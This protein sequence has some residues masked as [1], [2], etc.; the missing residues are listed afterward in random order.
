[1]IDNPFDILGLEP[2]YY[3]E[4]ELKKAYMEALQKNPPEK[5]PQG[6]KRIRK[7]YEDIKKSMS[8]YGAKLLSGYLSIDESLVKEARLY[9]EKKVSSTVDKET[10]ILKTIH[11]KILQYKHKSCK[12][13]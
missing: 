2:K 11:K 5:D 12:K 7:A 9:F 10:L 8:T 1:M 4:S 3:S 6:F 13:D